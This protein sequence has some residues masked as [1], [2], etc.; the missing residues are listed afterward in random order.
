MTFVSGDF[1]GGVTFGMEFLEDDMKF[2]DKRLLLCELLKSSMRCRPHTQ[3]Q[4]RVQ[5]SHE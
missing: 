4:S 1:W 2:Q 3:R 5:I